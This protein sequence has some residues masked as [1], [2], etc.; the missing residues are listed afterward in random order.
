MIDL[1]LGNNHIIDL[2]PLESL[3]SLKKVSVRRNAIQSISAADHWKSIE[4]FD[5]SGNKIV[6]VT[7]LEY[8]ESL[9]ELNLDSNKVEDIIPLRRPEHNEI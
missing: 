3:T 2:T 5:A 1:R 9:K 8:L 6:D 7:P 4:T